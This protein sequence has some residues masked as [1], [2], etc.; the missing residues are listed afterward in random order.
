MLCEVR[1]FPAVEIVLGETSVHYGATRREFSAEDLRVEQLDA[2]V[3][4]VN[5]LVALVT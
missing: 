4:V 3:L 2:G 5:R 1:N